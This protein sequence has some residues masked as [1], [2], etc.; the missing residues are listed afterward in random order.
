MKIMLIEDSKPKQEEILGHLLF[1][2]IHRNDIV[3]VENLTDFF[4]KTNADIGLFII[5]IRIPSVDNSNASQ[6]GKTIVES[7]V[8]MGRNDA[9]LLAISSYPEDFTHLRQYFEMH[10]CI[11][12]DFK[13]TRN[14]Q[15][16]L[17]HLLV[18][19]R[20]DAKFDFLIFCALE[21][22]RNPY[23]AWFS[24][25]RRIIRGGIECFD[26]EIAGKS[27]SVILH[28][29]MGL[30]NAAAA[31]AVSIDRYRPNLV[32]MSGICGGFKSRAYL[33]Q[34]LI[35]E[36][37]YEYQSG[38]WTGDGFSQ[39]PYQVPTEHGLL[40]SLRKLS[41]DSELLAELESGFKGSR[42]SDQNK[43]KTAVFTSGSA[44]IADK[45]YLDQVEIFHRKVSGL[46]ME[47]F[48]LQRA[49]HLSVTNPACICAK[50]VVDLC[51]NE[52]SDKIHAYGSFISAR[53]VIKAINDYYLNTHH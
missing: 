12:C 51:D 10:G 29:K 17:D 47:I 26:I 35:S 14:W 49:A 38:K 11:L 52:K 33:G 1:R 48:A 4:A 28:S 24:E 9:M 53:F 27:G 15:S 40:T 37:V 5:D 39:E 18:Q 44:V 13:E 30:V 34:L 21:E 31:S 20:R 25:G 36:M 22:E 50:V 45:K 8:K 23:I 42:P 16:T 7:L 41:D 2:G 6:N 19:A 46:D 32:A 43:P 3:I